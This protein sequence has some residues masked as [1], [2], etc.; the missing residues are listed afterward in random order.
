MRSRLRIGA[1]SL[2]TMLFAACC[3]AAPSNDDAEV[4]PAAP[5]GDE[6]TRAP[7]PASPRA[8][9][10]VVGDIEVTVY[11]TAVESFHSGA[12]KNITG[13]LIVDC[14]FGKS[15]LGSYPAS[16][17]RAVRTE[18]TG[19]ITSGPH[20]GRYLNW[21][22]DVG[23]WLDDIPSDSYGNALVPLSTAAAD[24]GV[25]RRG[26]R[27][28]LLAPLTLD[29]GEP[30]D[31]GI[32]AW[33]TGGVWTIQDEFTPGL[34][35]EGHIDIYLGEEDRADFTRTS[36]LYQTFIGASIAVMN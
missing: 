13:C 36:P 19:R 1:L 2:A 27:F 10:T 12:R 33:L 7:Q 22:Y 26:T 4:V 3:V 28:A 23:Y 14:A 21:S 34:G 17:A 18:G 30:A 24:I 9:G 29:N 11:Y 8:T 6:V 15:E 31:A 5:R 25:L 20:A 32:T 35:G 16:F